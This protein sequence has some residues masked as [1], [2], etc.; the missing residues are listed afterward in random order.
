MDKPPNNKYSTVDE[1]LASIPPEKRT[2]IEELRAAINQ[3]V[4]QAEEIISYNM[5]AFRYQGILLYYAAHKE[6]IGLYPGSSELIVALKDELKDLETSKGTIKFPFSRP[7]PVNLIRRIAE[8]RA[9]E[10][11]ERMRLRKQKR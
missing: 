5:P 8:Q 7:L 10:N 9:S 3:T 11:V 6:H 1:Y 4:P 2:M